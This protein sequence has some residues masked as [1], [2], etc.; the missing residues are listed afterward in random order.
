MGRLLYLVACLA[1][2]GVGAYVW[3]VKHTG[4]AVTPVVAEEAAVPTAPPSPIVVTVGGEKVTQEDVD[5][6]Y[7]VATNEVVGKG[8]LAAGGEDAGGLTPIPDLGARYQVE[9]LPLKRA[10]VSTIIERKVLY[11]Y[12]RVDKE[13][14][15]DDPA[16]YSACLREWQNAVSG[17][18][19]AV[20]ARGGKERLKARLCERSILDQY[21]RERVFQ[22]VAVTDAEVVEYFKN[23][24]GEFV[25]PE[26]VTIRQ[27]LVANESEAKRLRGQLNAANFADLAKR[28]SIA[29]EGEQGG[30]LGPFSQASVPSLFEIAAHM[31][32]GEISD[33]VKSP[34]GFHIVMLLEHFPK[35]ELGLDGAKPKIRAI[36]RKKREEE[37]YQKWVERALVAVSITTPKS[38]F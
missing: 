5:W 28:H 38:A 18:A 17:K 13:F 8:P 4:I 20:L 19:P 32:K 11:T 14:D 25:E 10:I 2:I 29:P 22:G 6:E 12:L 3:K 15:Y 33:V 1:C 35:R 27:I 34:Y 7:A 36:L 9:M 24:P 16:R 30:K 37:A 26:R 21:L 23:R 31:R